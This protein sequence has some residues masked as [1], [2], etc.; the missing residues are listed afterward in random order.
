[1][2]VFIYFL[3]GWIII[4]I[5][6]HVFAS[7]V[8]SHFFPSPQAF[9]GLFLVKIKN[10]IERAL[11]FS[12]FFLPVLRPFFYSFRHFQ[13]KTIVTALFFSFSFEKQWLFSFGWALL[14]RLIGYIKNKF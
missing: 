14:W 7:L 1:V 8:S 11:F 13:P 4:H 12:V 10:E 3:G 9:K 5:L 2:S 6:I